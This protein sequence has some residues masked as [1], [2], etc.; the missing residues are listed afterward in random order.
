[1]QLIP[2]FE[3]D[4]IR[5]G[6]PATTRRATVF[7]AMIDKR[8]ALIAR[9]ATPTTSWPRSR[10]AREHGPAASPSAPAAT[11]SPGMSLSTTGS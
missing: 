11:R 4:Q 6:D 8:P 2:S 7:N 3:G 5:P 9:C 10:C 1:M